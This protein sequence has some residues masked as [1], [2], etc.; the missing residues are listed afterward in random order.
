VQ[1]EETVVMI[2]PLSP[3]VITVALQLAVSKFSLLLMIPQ[4]Q[5]VKFSETGKQKL[6]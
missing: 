3:D 6:Q 1:H 2:S 5:T 4:G